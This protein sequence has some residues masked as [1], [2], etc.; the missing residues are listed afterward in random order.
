MKEQA[1]R[2]A[3]SLQTLLTKKATHQEIQKAKRRLAEY[4]ELTLKYSVVK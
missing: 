2:L 4:K 1:K 3:E